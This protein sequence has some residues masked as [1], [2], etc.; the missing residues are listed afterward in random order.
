M[1]TMVVA[2]TLWLPCRAPLTH[3]I[4]LV[5]GHK[6]LA[7]SVVSRESI[8]TCRAPGSSVLCPQSGVQ[9]Q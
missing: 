7:A 6:V 8:R 1:L 9:V 2:A 4:M 5:P 3:D